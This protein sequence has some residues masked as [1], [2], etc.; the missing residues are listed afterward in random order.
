MAR[1]DPTFN[2][3]SAAV[4]VGRDLW[5]GSYQADRIAVARA[6]LNFIFHC[7]YQFV[8]FACRAI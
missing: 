7:M 4:I 6:A 1:P 2:G 3:V 8:H 5:L